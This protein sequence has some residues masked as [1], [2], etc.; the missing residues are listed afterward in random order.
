MALSWFIIEVV[1]CFI[2]VFIWFLY[3]ILL[4]RVREF[5]SLLEDKKPHLFDAAFINR[6]SA[7]FFK[8]FILG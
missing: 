8:K 3:T 6:P 5:F 7:N 2:V 4:A 1:R